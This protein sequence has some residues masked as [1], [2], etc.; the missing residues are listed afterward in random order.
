MPYVRK[1]SYCWLNCLL[2]LMNRV[3]NDERVEAVW[4]RFPPALN[5]SLS[6]KKDRYHSR[7]TRKS[8]AYP[9]YIY[10]YRCVHIYYSSRSSDRV[11]LRERPSK[12]SYKFIL[13]IVCINTHRF[14][15]RANS[16]L[17]LVAPLKS[18]QCTELYTLSRTC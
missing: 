2:L 17:K 9:I 5:Q 1:H 14:C 11:L 13:S 7:V 4:N 6:L 12:P 16:I 10:T 8:E 15:G 18:L 3:N